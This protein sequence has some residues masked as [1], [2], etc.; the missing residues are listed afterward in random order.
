MRYRDYFYDGERNEEK[1]N[2][3][4]LNHY[5]W[6]EIKEAFE[7]SDLNKSDLARITGYGNSTITAFFEHETGT[8]DFIK[9]S[10]LCSALGLNPAEVIGN[11]IIRQAE[12]E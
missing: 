12:E 1:F 3:S 7:K 5:V 10:L 8:A 2:P 4:T 9:I 6:V 11:A